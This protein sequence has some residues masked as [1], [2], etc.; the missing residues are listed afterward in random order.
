MYELKKLSP[1][2]VCAA[3]DKAR[4]YRF[5]NEPGEAESIC[6]DILE[7][8]PGNT[9]ALVMLILA[10]TDQF[11]HHLTPKFDQAMELLNRLGD[12]YSKSYYE[13]LIC[14]R[15]GKA[16]MKRNQPGSGALA[17]EWFQKAMVLYENAMANSIAG[18]DDAVLRWNTCA[19]TLM[20]NPELKKTALVDEEQM[21]E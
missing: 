19:R 13:G 9:E 18:N 11:G 2:A 7:V 10:R 5:L 3:I 17:Y 15:R 16:H 21:L 14:E 4:C 12:A 8:E 20:E 6:L 1:G